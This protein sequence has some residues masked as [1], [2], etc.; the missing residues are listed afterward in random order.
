MGSALP[1]PGL[2]PEK[3][4]NYEL[5]LSGKAFNLVDYGSNLFFSQIDNTIDS[6]TLPN[7]SCSTPPA[8]NYRIGALIQLYL[9]GS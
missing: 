2:S 1:N 8:F 5:G 9:A 4:L 7:N 6:V 3:A